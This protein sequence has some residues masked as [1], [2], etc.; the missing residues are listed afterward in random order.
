[1]ITREEVNSLFARDDITI[2]STHRA[3]PKVIETAQG[4]IIKFF[5]PKSWLSSNTYSPYALRFCR[6]AINLNLRG[7]HAPIIS[8]I[9][10][11]AEMKTYLVCYQKIN[12]HT[13][14]NFN[15]AINADIIKLVLQLIADLHHHGV[16]FKAIHLSNFIYCDDG[17]LALIDIGDMKFK[18]KSL[19]LYARVKN[20]KTLF[21]YADDKVIWTTV[22]ISNCIDFYNSFSDLNAWQKKYLKYI[23][24]RA[25]NH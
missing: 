9:K 25:T 1:M 7:F 6:H 18:N 4:E 15:P 16:V 23:L 21:N 11:C 14:V 17:K 12:G 2:I 19:S 22:G 5:Y 8:S 3:Q 13:I 10:F 20:L 24:L